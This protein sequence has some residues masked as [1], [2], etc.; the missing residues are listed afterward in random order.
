MAFASRSLRAAGIE[1]IEQDV[2]CRLQV[3]KTDSNYY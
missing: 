2:S 3:F 1:H